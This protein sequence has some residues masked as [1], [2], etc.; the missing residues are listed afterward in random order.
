MYHSIRFILNWIRIGFCFEIG[1]MYH[2][3]RFILNWIRIGFRFEIGRMYHS[4][5]LCKQTIDLDRKSA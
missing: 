5:Q 2:S 4:N 3:I 1:C